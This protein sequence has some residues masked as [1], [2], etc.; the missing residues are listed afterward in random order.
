M[1]EKESKK[2]GV[3]P[4]LSP[5][6]KNPGNPFGSGEAEQVIAGPV[7]RRSG[8]PCQRNEASGAL[9]GVVSSGFGEIDL[10]EGAGHL[11]TGPSGDSGMLGGPAP[12][13]GQPGTSPVE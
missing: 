11:E 8:G 5:S 10:G 7:K 13:F 1:G 3:V 2:A 12:V 4:S 6:A 9:L